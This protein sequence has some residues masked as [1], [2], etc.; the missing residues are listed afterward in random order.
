MWAAAPLALI[1]LGLVAAQF[2]SLIGATYNDADAASAPVIGELFHAGHGQQVGLGQLPWYSTLIYELATRGLPLHRQ[3]WEASPYAMALLSVALV[4]WATWQ[5]AGRWAAGIAATLLICASP[6]T[7]GLLFSLNDH[8]P[9]WFSLALLGAYLVFV[10]RRF[11]RVSIVWSVALTV[12]VGVIVGINA[13]SDDLLIASGLVPIAIAGA[14]AWLHHRT[15]ATRRA[16]IACGGLVAVSALS[17]LIT[18]SAM[19]SAGVISFPQADFGT[20]EQ[21]EANFHL[22][23]QSLSIIADGNF[24]GQSPDFQSVL[25]AACAVMAIAAVLYAIRAAYKAIA[26]PRPSDA[27]GAPSD[28]TGVPSDAVRSAHV[29]FWGSSALLLSAA[30]IL[31]SAPIDVESGRYLVGLLYAAAAVVPLIGLRGTLARAA[32]VAG[33]AVFALTGVIGAADETATS[34]TGSF[35]TASLA[36]RIATL[37]RSLHLDRGYAGYWDAAPITWQSNFGVHVYPLYNC[38]SNRLC[39]APLHFISSWY[40][41]H[42]GPT[43]LLVDP[44]QPFVPTAPAYLGKPSAAYSI[45]QITMFVYPYDIAAQ[46]HA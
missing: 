46:L 35:P 43:F 8:S 16:A 11:A 32:V 7:L 14:G 15:D 30:F 18:T 39:P 29:L 27:T 13:A 44:T 4:A 23:W 42:G 17:A 6:K 40:G 24:F 9:T 26:T 2:G 3:I 45:G 25:E 20:A 38:G 33:T 5:V 12:L 41:V 28:A 34:N 37:A 22:W 10:E 31:S 36:T 1:Y 19:H 21:I